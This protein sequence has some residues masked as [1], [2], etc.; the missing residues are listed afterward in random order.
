MFPIDTFNE[1][2]VR[3]ALLNAISHRD[4]QIA[5]SVF[6]RQFRDKLVV[7]SP[8]GFPYGITVDNILNRQSPRNLLIAKI[9]QL[10]GLV[11]RS[12][13]GMNLI[14]ELAVRE[15]KPLP[16][17]RGTDAYFVRLTLSGQVIDKSMLATFKK[18]GDER[19]EKMTTDDYILLS[20][21]FS[22]KR[23][24]GI[25]PERF[26][27]LAELGIVEQ[28]ANGIKIANGESLSVANRSL[29]VAATDRKQAVIDFLKTNEQA[30]TRDLI[31]VVG[32][33]DGRV[34]ALLRTMV[35]D[36]TIEKVGNNRFASYRLT[37]NLL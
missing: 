35:E 7:E 36:G 31:E 22:D 29:S 9:F 12:G 30:K 13:Q 5:G 1:R 20:K 23:H 37:E 17:F 10:C 6:V 32:L 34:R 18:I 3:E 27:H 21:L 16:D 4:Y 14:Y 8:G 11:E 24:E 15:A 33:S 25:Q 2:I 26:A 19:L 28:T